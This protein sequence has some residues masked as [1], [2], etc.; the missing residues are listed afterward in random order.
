[1]P[2]A[3]SLAN[4]FSKIIRDW[5]TPE[6]CDE[7]DVLNDNEED[8]SICHSHDYCDP[9]QA[10]IDAFAKWGVELDPQNYEHNALCNKAWAIAKKERFAYATDESRS[11]GPRR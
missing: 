11:F 5:L 3:Q 10:M 8:A 6:E 4:A 2:D 9:N 1:M 7:I